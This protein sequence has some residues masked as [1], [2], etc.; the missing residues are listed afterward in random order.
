MFTWYI[1]IG[2][3]EILHL[4]SARFC[5]PFE[6]TSSCNVVHLLLV[7]IHYE[8]LW[9]VSGMAVS[10]EWVYWATEEQLSMN[11][12][13]GVYPA[14]KQSSIHERYT[15]LFYCYYTEKPGQCLKLIAPTSPGDVYTNTVLVMSMGFFGL[16]RRVMHCWFYF[17]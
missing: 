7:H 11:A 2:D 3:Y 4:F 14:M 9:Q 17:G 15:K 16:C 8:T 1:C 12:H 13:G 5:A 6:I 10:E